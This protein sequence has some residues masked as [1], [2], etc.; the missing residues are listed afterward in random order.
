MADHPRAPDGAGQRVIDPAH[1]A[2]LF[3]AKPRA[4]VM[5]YRD[6]L[7]A[8]GGRAPAFV[9]ELSRRQPDQLRREILALHA[10]YEQVGVDALVTAMARAEAAGSYS[11]ATVGLLLT[12]PAEQPPFPSLPVA[13][14]PAQHEVDRALS[15]YEAWVQVAEAVAR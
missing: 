2:P 8:L 6:A 3:P 10:L 15:V 11:A 7:L 1:F 13:G 14:L 4:Q 9:G 12:T 5:L